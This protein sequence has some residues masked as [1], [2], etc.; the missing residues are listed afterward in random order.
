MQEQY[1]AVHRYMIV[2]G[3]VLK[4]LV[5][6]PDLKRTVPTTDVSTDDMETFPIETGMS[7]TEVQEYTFNTS[8]LS[9]SAE[10]YLE[11]WAKIKNRRQVNIVETDSEGDAFSPTSVVA[12]YD[13]GKCGIGSVTYPSGTKEA[14][15]SG[16]VKVEILARKIDRRRT[17]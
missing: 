13:L 15:T 5:E 2:D 12:N 10:I 14:P 11:S 16:K 7:K 17:T 9:D 3:V 1:Y 4:D 6:W 8:K